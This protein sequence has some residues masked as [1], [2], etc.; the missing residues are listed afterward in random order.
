MD[1]RDQQEIVNPDP[2]V[3]SARTDWNFPNANAHKGPVL[4][5]F[6]HTG[7]RCFLMLEAAL[8]RAHVVSMVSIF[9]ARL[10]WFCNPS[11]E[12]KIYSLGNLNK[13]P[14]G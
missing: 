12:I 4:N 10:Q 5:M 1:A 2:I 6:N 8:F 11:C 14:L 7:P 9:Q 3:G 13:N